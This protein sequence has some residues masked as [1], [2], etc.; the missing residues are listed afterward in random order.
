MPGDVICSDVVSV[1][2]ILLLLDIAPQPIA[3]ANSKLTI[4]AKGPQRRT[5]EG[6]GVIGGLR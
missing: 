1:D 3:L 6:L 2:N 5:S 4:D